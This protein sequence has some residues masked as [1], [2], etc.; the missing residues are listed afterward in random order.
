MGNRREIAL[1]GAFERHNFG[2]WLLA[3]CAQSLISGEEKIPWLFDFPSLGKGISD[4]CGPYVQLSEYLR[5]AVRPTVI[6]VGGE[7]L[8][9]DSYSAAYMANQS[10][11]SQRP[12]H[13]VLPEYVQSQKVTRCFFGVGGREV[14]AL[15]HDD[16]FWLAQQLETA[17]WISVRDKMSKLQL[18]EMGIRSE[19]HPDLVTLLSRLYPNA[20]FPDREEKLVVQLS[21][22][23]LLQDVSAFPAF[24]EKAASQFDRVDLLVAGVAPGHDSILHYAKAIA[25]LRPR[26]RN[27]SVV[28][29]LNPF[30]IVEA[31]STAS[32]VVASSLH[33]RIVAMSYGV[34]CVSV[35]VPKV[36]AYARQW[37]TQAVVVP[38]LEDAS[39]GIEKV[40]RQPRSHHADLAEELVALTATSWEKMMEAL[41]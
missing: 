26:A 41:Q 35:G 10:V 20:R 37:D 33:F 1:F 21:L 8:G 25:Y 17:E 12:L 13:Y 14:S 24:L 39:L 9:C 2:D 40:L 4:N 22:A 6:H 38:T 23:V 29:D 19:L 36:I 7:T 30:R 18:D 28:F 15:V 11:V 31:I 5:T 32:R 16:R 3:F 34:P 27:V